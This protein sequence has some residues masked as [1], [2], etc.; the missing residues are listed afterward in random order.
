MHFNSKLLFEKYAK[1]FFKSRMRVLEI[2]PDKYPSSTNKEI[3]GDD[4]ITWE[5]L[6]IFNSD[7]L[8]H[9]GEGEYKF[10]VPNDT[11]DIVLRP[12]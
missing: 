2:G 6:D 8:T 7:S 12:R 1:P 4:T 5:T 11:F 10:S 3:I 9:V